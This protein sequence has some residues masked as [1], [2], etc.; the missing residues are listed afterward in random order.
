VIIRVATLDEILSLRHA[1]LRPGRALD[2]ASFDGDADPT[3]IHVVACDGPDIV[4]CA[5]IMRR[6]FEREDAAQ[7]RGMATSPTHTRRGVGTAVLR[8][9]ET[10]V[11]DEWRLPLAWCNARLSAVRFY[12]HA[13]WEVVSST[14]DVPDVGP[15]VGMTRRLRVP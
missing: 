6:P 14:F 12:E 5:T 13:G 2:T 9:V 4:G 1:V 8:F 3:T 10:L 15:H 7:L 11:A